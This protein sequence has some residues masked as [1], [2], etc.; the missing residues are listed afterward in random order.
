MIRP[1]F[2]LFACLTA[3]A[4]ATSTPQDVVAE[5]G[6]AVRDGDP[7]HAYALLSPELREQTP[8][9]EFLAQ[10][11]ARRQSLL[12]SAPGFADARDTPAHVTAELGYNDYDT[13]KMTLGPNGWKLSGGVLSIYAQ[14][15]P[16]NALVSFVRALES[17][18]HVQLMHF[19]PSDYAQHM[20]PELLAA[21]LDKRKAEVDDLVIELK[22][23]LHE[24]I[25]VRGAQAFLRY[26]E[27]KVT[28]VLEGDAWKIEDPD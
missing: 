19:I 15:T 8:Y 28:L 25:S 13:L 21:D 17:R 4:C 6:Q 26:G 7:K 16:R 2:L 18:D 5:Y 23:N 10:W 20:T 24:P 3:S 27:H 11:R 1:A 22:A 9:P 14:D 12:G